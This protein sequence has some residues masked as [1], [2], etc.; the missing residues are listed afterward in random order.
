V[1]ETDVLIDVATAFGLGAVEGPASF[2]DGGVSGEVFKVATTTGEWAVKRLFHEPDR[3]GLEVQARLQ[4]AA[5]AAGVASPRSMRTADGRAVA[6]AGG[7]H[8]L[9]SEWADVLRDPATLVQRDRLVM[10]GDIAATLHDLRLGAPHGVTPWL[11]TPP[12]AAEWGELRVLVRA[13]DPPWASGF[14]ELYPELVRLAEFAGSVGDEAAVL[15]HCDLGPANF[16]AAAHRLVVFD[17]ERAGA[18]PP[19][20]ELGYVLTHWAGLGDPAAIVPPIV[21]GYRSRSRAQIAVGRDMFAYAANAYLNFLRGA[22]RGAN[23]SRVVGLLHDP[24]TL[25]SVETLAD[26]ASGRGVR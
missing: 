2:V 24:M 16:G 7:A 19:A 9:A 4:D 1:V 14:E 20:Q 8:W 15:S 26:L 17:W 5:R 21:A 23:E 6:T 3:A 18:I 22:I 13:S 12:S 10:V 11:T 25:D